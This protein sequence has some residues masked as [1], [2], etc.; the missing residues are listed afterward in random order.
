MTVYVTGMREA[1]IM[2]TIT[3]KYNV[4][5]KTGKVVNGKLEGESREAV[6]TK[7]R[8]MG[9]IV[10]DLEEDR[11]AQLNKIQFG[12]SVKTKDVTIFARQFAT[13][14]NAGLSLTK[15]LSILADQVESK[16]LRDVIS[17]LNK[18]VEAG[19]S[20]SEAMMKHPKIFPPLFYNM[21]KA[22]ETG[23]VLDEVLLRVA[24][25]MEQDAQLKGRVKSAMMY[26]MVISIL[27]VVVV[28]AMMVFVVPTFID[29]FSGAGQELPLPTQILVAISNYTASIK[30]VITAIVLAILYV[31]FKQWT[32]TNSGKFI[33]DGI[34]LRMPVAGNIIRKTSVARFTRTFGT[35]VSAGV[36]ILSAMDIVADTAGNEVVTRALKTARGAIKEGETIAKPL[37][38]SP[39]FPGMVVQMVA[40]GEETGALDQMLTK[41]ADFYD[42]EVGTAI[43]GLASAMEPIIMVVLAVVVGGIVIALYM[44]MFQSVTMVGG[45]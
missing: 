13:M 28:I 25:L 3:F 31:V 41:I 26:P 12:T 42:E 20:L 34:K 39:V 23:G 7:L 8:Q 21:V 11:I 9:Y 24:D 45:T 2:A 36:P 38:E 43:D 10:L 19:Q 16:E 5:D 22:G 27:V 29:M 35:L 1:G 4:R 6:A 33:W 18:D 17:Q 44:P 37:S 14:I 30:G 32:N 40:V 15:C